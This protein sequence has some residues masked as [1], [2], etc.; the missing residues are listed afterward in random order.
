MALSISSQCLAVLLGAV[1]VV[2][3]DLPLCET[4]DI[5]YLVENCSVRR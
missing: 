4:L 3:K 1:F 2:L 5:G